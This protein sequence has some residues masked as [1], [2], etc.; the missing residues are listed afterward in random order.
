MRLID[1]KVDAP[2]LLQP[3]E[4]AGERLLTGVSLRYRCRPEGEVRRLDP[5]AHFR[6]ASVV[7]YANRCCCQ[8]RAL[9]LNRPAFPIAWSQCD[10]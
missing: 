8:Y 10:L 4:F 6:L 9:T 5:N 7:P 1:L 3:S 2:G